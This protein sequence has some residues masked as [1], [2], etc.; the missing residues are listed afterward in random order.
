MYPPKISKNLLKNYS[1]IQPPGPL[2][3]TVHPSKE[4]TKKISRTPGLLLEVSTTVHQGLF[5]ELG[6][7]NCNLLFGVGTLSI[8]DQNQQ[9]SSFF[10]FVVN[11]MPFNK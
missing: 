8:A 4:F 2:P 11:R 7:S 1:K 3:S 10:V 5:H 9:N 6:S